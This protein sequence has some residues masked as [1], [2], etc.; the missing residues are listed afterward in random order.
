MVGT[1]HFRCTSKFCRKINE[2]PS[3][4]ELKKSCGLSTSTSA[5]AATSSSGALLKEEQRF[6]NHSNAGGQ[7]SDVSSALVEFLYFQ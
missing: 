5:S 3:C 2:S 4:T 1:L 6:T 7:L